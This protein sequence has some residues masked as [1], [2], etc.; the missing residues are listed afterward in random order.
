MMASIAELRLRNF[1]RELVP[2]QSR[3]TRLVRSIRVKRGCGSTVTTDS[4]D[5]RAFCL[6]SFVLRGVSGS[7]PAPGHSL[8]RIICLLILID[9]WPGTAA[10]KAALQ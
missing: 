5:P 7:G 2:G 1:D 8:Q 9:G 6:D 4:F 3:V 10:S